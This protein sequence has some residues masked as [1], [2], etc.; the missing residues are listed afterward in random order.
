MEPKI[1]TLSTTVSTRSETK[2]QKIT[3]T[4]GSRTWFNR[5]D[6]LVRAD[7]EAQPFSMAIIWGF[8]KF[9]LSWIS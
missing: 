9:Y 8:K 3:E 4:W 5:I 6:N 2:I 1:L 7:K